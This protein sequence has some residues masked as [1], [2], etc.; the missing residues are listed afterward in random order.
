MFAKDPAPSGRVRVKICGITTLADALAA[1]HGGA[2]AL[3]FNFFPQS[4]RYVNVRTESDWMA[5]LPRDVLKVAVMVDPTWSELTKA[6]Q[7]SFIDAIQLHGSEPVE[8]CRRVA[9]NQI[10]FAKALPV[11]GPRPLE[12]VPDFFTDMVILDSNTPRGFGGS[13]EKFDWMIGSKF[14]EQNPRLR[15]IVAGGLT[16]EN[17]A[18]AVGTIRPFGVDVTSGVESSAGRKDPHRVQAFIAAA[19]GSF[20]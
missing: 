6:A 3:G 18:E 8:F 17:V 12:N 13:G 11:A 9:E 7:L 10:P 16:P 2:D 19:H 15:V 1:I 20:K 4:K 14:V 5:T